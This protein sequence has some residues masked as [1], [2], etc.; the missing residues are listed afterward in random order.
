MSSL[1]LVNGKKYTSLVVKIRKDSIAAFL[2][3][4]RISQWMT[5]YSD[6]SVGAKLWD[7]GPDCVG[8]ELPWT[9]RRRSIP[10]GCFPSQISCRRLLWR[11]KLPPRQP[12]TPQPSPPP[13]TQEQQWVD[14]LKDVNPSS[15]SL[16][17]TWTLADGDLTAR[18]RQHIG[19][20]ALTLSFRTNRP[21]NMT[22]AFRS[23]VID[24]ETS[25][26][27]ICRGGD[28]HSSL[29]SSRRLQ[30]RD[31]LF[32]GLGRAPKHHRLARTM[33]LSQPPSNCFD[34]SAERWN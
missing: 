21:R 22:C 14:L 18:R 19:Q 4:K 5:D 17:G 11:P 15:D 1:R 34:Q 30:R 12:L 32:T 10:H 24:P 13:A 28:H 9:I 23:S 3:G 8:V 16:A 26:G 25:L 27:F 20:S 6:L 33:D 2:D 7:M 29:E 31:V